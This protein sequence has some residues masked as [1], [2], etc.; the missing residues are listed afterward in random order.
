MK[1]S[2]VLSVIALLCFA[3]TERDAEPNTP[4]ALQRSTCNYWERSK[5]VDIRCFTYLSQAGFRLPLALLSKSDFAAK[6][7]LMRIPGGPGNGLQTE[8][9]ALDYFLSWYEQSEIKA[10]VLIFNPRGVNGGEPYWACPEYDQISLK[11]LAENISYRQESEQSA[12]VLSN[13]LQAYDD[14]L[15]KEIGSGLSVFRSAEQAKDVLGILA[16]LPY[17]D[18]HLWGISYGTRL[19]LKSAELAGANDVNLRSLILDSAY[20]YHAGRQSEWASLQQNLL[21]I[22][23]AR[24]REIRAA[25]GKQFEE[26]WRA[27]MGTV[28]ALSNKNHSV[29]QFKIN[30]W[31]YGTGEASRPLNTSNT[32]L[33]YLNGHRMQSLLSFVSYDEN[34]LGD[35]YI[36]LEELA[37][38][39][40][41]RPLPQALVSVAEAF[42]N[43]SFDPAFS[44]MVFY[45]TE[46]GDNKLESP[47]Q[48]QQAGETYPQWQPYLSVQSRFNVC[49][50]QLFRHNKAFVDGVYNSEVRTLILAGEWDHVSP[51][52]WAKSLHGTLKDGGADAQL[53][54]VPKAGHNLIGSGAC[55]VDLLAHWL[56]NE[57]PITPAA[58]R[59]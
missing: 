57:Q 58:C 53:L 24:Y 38:W 33:V 34:L 2:F 54:I 40:H 6:E 36:A 14:F 18:I 23:A 45:S 15:K 17:Q 39:Q 51:P 56:S 20:P 4:S 44:S 9:D 50:H 42:V 29:L 43:A 7:L 22:H 8:P 47:E 41:G 27:A 37:V 59:S 32:Y 19:A 10:D 52:Q 26:I 25:D 35:F 30:N 28:N 48:W 5:L 46:C 3:C 21:H 11:L 16:L 13:C 49:K 31:H 1:L 12:E 55:S